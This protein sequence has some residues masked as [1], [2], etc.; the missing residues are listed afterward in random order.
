MY[1]NKNL[2]C[3]LCVSQEQYDRLR[4]HPIIYKS[5]RIFNGFDITDY[6]PKNKIAKN[7]NTV[8]Y[9]GSLVP[10]KGFHWLAQA[11]P[12]VLKKKPNA[13]LIVMGTGKLYDD[14]AKLG[15]WGVAEEGYE[16]KY[17]R[18]YLSNKEGEPHPS[19]DFKGLVGVEKIEI[20]Q[21]VDVGV[22]NPSGK[23]ENCPGSALEF[24]AAGTPVVSSAKKGIL[25]TVLHNHTG[26]LGKNIRDLSD[27][28]IK[29]L[30]TSDLA[31]RYGCNAINFVDDKFNWEKIIGEWDHLFNILKNGNKIDISAIENFKY[32]DLK[33]LREKLRVAK[34]YTG[35]KN[36]IN[37]SIHSLSGY[38]KYY[39]KNLV[40]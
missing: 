21:H 37:P 35:L 31:Y 20:M 34:K 8:A 18:P 26:L 30:S 12:N 36:Y 39:K 24:Q 7:S 38:I 15:K 6:K 13:K 32:N 40:K 25:D 17:I 23:S 11:W 4:D 1:K 33:I 9:I 2:S 29:L 28:I 10:T 16:G 19:V 3:F 14:S 5:H 22:I 27:N